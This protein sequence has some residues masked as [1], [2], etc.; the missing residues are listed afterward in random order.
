MRRWKLR[1]SFK[2]VSD[3]VCAASERIAKQQQP[4]NN[5]SKEKKTWHRVQI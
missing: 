2:C 3:F 5:D 1:L 4:G